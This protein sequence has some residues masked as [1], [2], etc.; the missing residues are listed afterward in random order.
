MAEL[1]TNKAGMVPV[2]MLFSDAGLGFRKDEVRGF[3]PDVAAT[4]IERK[5]AV[6]VDI[7][8]DDKPGKS[9]KAE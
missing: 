9:A 1:K 4:M 3:A 6:A 5:H 7:P 2:R 8:P